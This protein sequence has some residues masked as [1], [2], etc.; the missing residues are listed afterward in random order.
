M[1]CVISRHTG[2]GLTRAARRLSGGS[3]RGGLE[4]CSIDRPTVR[5]RRGT[6]RRNRDGA[7]ST[8]PLRRAICAT[9]RSVNPPDEAVV[10][11][12]VDLVRLKGSGLNERDKYV[13]DLIS[14]RLIAA[15]VLIEMV[16]Y[17]RRA[18]L[19][20]GRLMSFVPNRFID[21]DSDAE[22]NSC[23]SGRSMIP[24]V[25]EERG[26]PPHRLGRGARPRGGRRDL[27][28]RDQRGDPRPLSRRFFLRRG[29][30][31]L[32]APQYNH[33]R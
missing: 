33:G 10:H 22:R 15:V 4:R 32:A 2:S 18:R 3:R 12:P 8:A 31:L 30:L 1:C 5:E 19:R 13:S 11:C 28:G 29:S 21:D 26:G 25:R 17:Y 27:H 24:N 7:R 9:G 23:S 20:G 14:Q 6:S 16:G